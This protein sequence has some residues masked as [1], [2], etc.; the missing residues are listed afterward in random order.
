METAKPLAPDIAYHAALDARMVKV[1]RDLRVLALVSWPAGAEATYLES[2][3][4][5]NARPPVIDYPRCDFSEARAELA[6]IVREA[7]HDHPLGQ[8][9]YDSAR[10]WS[11]NACWYCLPASS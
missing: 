5:G 7:D 3:A 6:A 2:Y 10:S 4:R 11:I 9:I 1:A 8:Y